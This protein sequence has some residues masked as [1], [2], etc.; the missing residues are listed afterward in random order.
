MEEKPLRLILLFVVFGL[1]GQ[2]LYKYGMNQGVGDIVDSLNGD[3]AMLLQ[4]QVFSA[5]W[6]M[7][8]HTVQMVINPYVFFGLVA[9]ALSTVCWLGVLSKV[10]L[11][12]AYPMISI[13][14]VAVLLMSIFT[15]GEEVTMFRWMG[16]GLICLGIVSIYSEE[17]F[18]KHS[19]FVLV[20]LAVCMF[21]VDFMGHKVQPAA[22]FEKPVLFIAVTLSLGIIGQVFFKMGMNRPVNKNRI[23]EITNDVK[24]CLRAPVPSTIHA[25]WNTLCL[26]FSPA[27]FVGLASYAISTILWVMLLKVVP[28]SF[29]YPLLSVGYVVI[30][31]ISIMFFHE[32]VSFLR[33]YGVFTIC[34]GIVF[35]FAESL[36]SRHTSYATSGLMVLIVS[37][38]LHSR[39]YIKETLKLRR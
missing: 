39:E 28:L 13:G 37:L 10:D 30:M 34:F 8:K 11:S 9:Y 24:Q 29:L 15:F 18:T 33:W 22:E 4:G 32:R 1:V 26:F 5:L 14:Y 27:V 31:V 35:V 3:W 20:F 23:Q 25:L 36:I 6:Q 12:F 38:V 17:W 16:V 19:P 7:T 21:L 2:F